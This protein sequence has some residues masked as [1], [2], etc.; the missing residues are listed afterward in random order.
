MLDQP[1]REFRDAHHLVGDGAELFVE[2]DFPK[3]LRLLFERDPEILLPEE[4]RVGEAGG[5][6]AFVAGDD[7][8]AAVGP[9]DVGGADEVRGQPPLPVRQ[10]E[11]FLVCPHG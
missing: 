11:I 4:F 9:L 1:S 7:G 6:D 10:R 5:E 3:L 2:D 8:G